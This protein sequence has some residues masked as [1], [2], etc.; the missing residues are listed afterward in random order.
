MIMDTAPKKYT[1]VLDNIGNHKDLTT[2]TK[3]FC[4]LEW[5]KKFN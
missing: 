2:Q 5:A 1:T 4:C 3:V